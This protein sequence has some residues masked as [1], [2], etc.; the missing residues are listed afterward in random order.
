MNKKLHIKKGDTVY[1][2][3]GD[4]RGKTGKVLE[5]LTEKSRA[6]VEGINLVSKHT[7]PNAKHP[8]GGIIK[9]EAGVHLSNLQVVDPVKGGPTRIGR[10]LNDKQKLVRYS[11]KSGEEIK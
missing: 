4:D 6:I 3:A 7:K 8:Q 10:R 9:Q 2:N 11:K 1:V 5:V